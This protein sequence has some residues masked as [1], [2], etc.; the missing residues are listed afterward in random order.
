MAPLTIS[1]CSVFNKGKYSYTI[2][3]VT[4]FCEICFVLYIICILYTENSLQIYFD[5][6]VC[7]I[8]ELWVILIFVLI[9]LSFQNFH[10]CYVLL[11]FL[12]DEFFK[13]TMDL[14]DNFLATTAPFISLLHRP[15]TKEC[16]CSAM[17]LPLAFHEL[18]LLMRL[19]CQQH[20]L[21]SSSSLIMLR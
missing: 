2:Y 7:W 17:Y 12:K 6:S 20:F 16:T 4:K 14:M 9:I 1:F 11:K 13:S 10:N 18:F 19:T 5:S 21:F 8:V 3:N 15:Q